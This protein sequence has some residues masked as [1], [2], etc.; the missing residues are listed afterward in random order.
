MLCGRGFQ[1]GTKMVCRVN[2]TQ[3]LVEL[4]HVESTHHGISMDSKTCLSLIKT[5]LST[6]TAY[7]LPNLPTVGLSPESYRYANTP[8]SNQYTQ[9]WLKYI[10]PC[11]KL[12][13]WCNYIFYIWTSFHCPS[14]LLS[15][16]NIVWLMKCLIHYY[17]ILHNI[18]SDKETYLQQK[19][20]GSKL[21]L[22]KLTSV[23]SCVP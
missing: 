7:G 13:A 9:K 2:V 6:P 4:S 23:S 15:T 18:I 5:D 21:L 3:C 10:S 11:C 20:Y 12:S 22:M 14:V 8:Q 17:Y 19:K 1:S 16:L